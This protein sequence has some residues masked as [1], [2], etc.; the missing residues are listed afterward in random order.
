M[1]VPLRFQN[2]EYD[3]GTVSFINALTYLYDREEFPVELLKKI[4]RYTLD[5]EKWGIVGRGGTSRKNAMKLARSFVKYTNSHKK[6]TLK[7]KILSKDK[8]NIE[9]MREC[10]ANK[11]VIIARC[12]HKVEHYVIITKLDDKYGYLFDPYYEEPN[13][14]DNDPDIKMVFYNDFQHNRIVTIER[15]FSETLDD[16][17]LLKKEDREIILMNR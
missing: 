9:E 15:L 12:I 14:Y 5:I 11:G 6:F 7:C 10:L 13:Y 16:Y 17:S 4:H 2:T 8:V 1:K 3:C